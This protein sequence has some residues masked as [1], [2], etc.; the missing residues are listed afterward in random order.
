MT[1]RLGL[2]GGIGSGKSTVAAMFARLGA[3]V[4]DA[5]AVSR[6]TTAAGG[7]AMLAI[8][9]VFGASFVAADGSLNRQAMREHIF[10]TPSAKAQLEAIIHPLVGQEIKRLEQTAVASGSQLIIFDIPLLVES[11]HW[12]P[13]LD[14]VFVVDC[15]P[16]TQIQRV[17]QR[18]GWPRAQVQQAIAAQADRALRLAAADIVIFNQGVDIQALEQQVQACRRQIGLSSGYDGA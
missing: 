13:R 2:T 9:K 3:D 15:D 11:T 4:I 7:A 1:I 10:S 16:E 14:L 17:M 18:S 6:Q 12:R 5:D 8:S